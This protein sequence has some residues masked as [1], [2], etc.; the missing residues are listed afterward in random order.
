MIRQLRKYR[1]KL[2]TDGAVRPQRMAM[3]VADDTLLRDGAD[4]LLLFGED[5]FKRCGALALII[6]EPRLP[7]QT[8]VP[9][10]MSADVHQ[11]IPLDTETRTFLHDI[12]LIRRHGGQLDRG[13]IAAALRRRKGV[14]VEGVGLIAVGHVTVEQAYVNLSSL[15]HALF[16]GYLSRLVQVPR[17][18]SDE[19]KGFI[20]PIIR[21]LAIDIPMEINDFSS[22]SLNS[23][24]AALAAMDQA[25][26]RTV[27]LKLV[28]SFFGNVSSRLGDAILISQTGAA[29][30]SLVGCIDLV[31]DDNSSTAGITA[32]SEL[33]AHRAIY[34]QTSANVILHGHPKFSVISS[35]LC[36]EKDCPVIDCWQECT[37]SRFVASVP[38]VA[39]EIGAGG[40]AATLPA[41]MQGEIAIVYGHGV[42]ASGQQDFRE[43]LRAMIALENRCRRGYLHQ[44]TEIYGDDFVKRVK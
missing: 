18:L 11:L 15:Y 29:L 41:A 1:D 7:L 22:E 21:T 14:L 3:F 34:Q 39:G 37:R 27:E 10:S 20:G 4:D 28:D 19:E 6:A 42:F 32:S 23:Q 26:R 9:M 2:E 44:L 38:V 8:L 40:I 24:S 5:V 33:A 25:G 16:V 36:E 43:P 35:L 30:D 12:P 31:P 13:E 17:Y